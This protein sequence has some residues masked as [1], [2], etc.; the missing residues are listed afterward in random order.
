MDIRCLNNTSI[1][2]YD[3]AAFEREPSLVNA[4]LPWQ[5]DDLAHALMDRLHVEL[6]AGE[7]S[8]N[9]Y[10]IG[11]TL[12]YPLPLV[13]R[14]S[15]LPG[16]VPGV[17]SYPWM[18]WLMWR[19]EERWRV[20]HTAWRAFGDLAAG[21][22][23]QQELAAL[24]EW[25]SFRETD[26]RVHLVTGHVAAILAMALANAQGWEP[27]AYCRAAAAAKKLLHND[28][29]PWF[30]ATWA[31]DAPITLKRIH[32]IPAIVLIRSAQLARVVAYDT[33]EQFEKRSVA[34]ISAWCEY[35]LH[36][37][38]TEGAAYDGF[39][40]DSA[41]EWLDT[42]PDKEQR[43]PALQAAL[44]SFCR[45]CIGL[46]LP[47]RCDILAPLGDVE[48]EMPFWTT[49]MLRMARWFGWKDAEWLARQ[50]PV[51]RL[52]AAALSEVLMHSIAHVEQT[53][54]SITQTMQHPASLTLRTGWANSDCL[55]AVGSSGGDNGH[56]HY[57]GGSLVLGWHKR[58][59]ITDPGYQQYRRGCERDYTIGVQAH[60][61]PVVGDVAQSQRRVQLLALQ[62]DA[63]QRQHAALELTRCYV[64]LP[65]E[66]TIHREIWLVA[67]WGPLIAVCDE[68]TGLPPGI[69]ITNYWLGGAQLSWSFVDGWAR[70]HDGAHAVWIGTT[71]GSIKPE[72]L[73]KHEGS[74]GPLTLAHNYL[75]PDGKG[76]CWWLFCCD[77]N[78]H[79][80]PPPQAKALA[81]HENLGSVLRS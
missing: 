81:E 78:A 19:L 39:L 27:A 60:N 23:L 14:P 33:A 1:P 31:D 13:Q 79:W 73:T 51:T 75:L 5:P 61:A 64:G 42:L 65:A 11:Y 16:G 58:F 7:L 35:R 10:R 71:Q 67:E 22:L 3:T 57:D 62:T 80:T 37:Q 21:N 70:L 32:N 52:P 2:I 36:T 4:H 6:P 63:N 45:Q 47:G 9:Y 38:H 69:C 53:V 26:D 12:A 28:V 56:L 15:T 68:F 72:R 48:P 77:Q 18:I 34:A 24:S 76:V 20:L 55:A 59:W 17:A 54:P 74:R 49:V 8:V 41:T 50:V 46:A 40:L 44:H 43:L 25:E 30:M 66:A 29:M